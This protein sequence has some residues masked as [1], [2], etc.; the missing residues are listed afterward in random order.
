ML[1]EVPGD[2]P[3]AVDGAQVVFNARLFLRRGKEVT[4]DAEI[5]SGSGAT[6]PTRTVGGIELIDRV[7]E[8]GKRRTIAGVELSLRGMRVHGYRE[9][10]VSPHLAYG[11]EGAPDGIP[12]NAVLRIQLWL[13]EVVIPSYPPSSDQT[14]N[15]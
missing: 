2:G 8:L 6:L 1:N 9:V 3:L 13:Q 11:Q 15:Q 12:A 14:P 4:R 5:L 10:L 7:T